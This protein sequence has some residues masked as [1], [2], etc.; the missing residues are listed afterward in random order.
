MS[1][2][3]KEQLMKRGFS[4]HPIE[5]PPGKMN[6]EKFIQV[7]GMEKPKYEYETVLI[8]PGRIVWESDLN[9]LGEQGYRL[10]A[11]VPLMSINIEEGKPV[12]VNDG[13]SLI[14]ERRKETE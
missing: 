14:F 12:A 2:E 7:L 3:A 4:M 8:H 11:T 6:K 13:S 5:E 9:R 1:E 10:V